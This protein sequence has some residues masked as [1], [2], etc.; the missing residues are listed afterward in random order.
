MFDLKDMETMHK[1]TWERLVEMEP[2]LEALL[3]DAK[4][5]RPRRKRGFNYELAWC[6]FK[7]PVAKL[8]G[9]HRRDDCDPLLKSQAAYDVA[10]WKLYH[11]LHD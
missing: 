5:S 10:Y 8:V 3:F 2:R 11:A 1:L 6:E 7:L 9:W 4:A